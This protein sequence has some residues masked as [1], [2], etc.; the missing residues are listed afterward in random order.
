M[1]CC[2]SCFQDPTVIEFIVSNSE[3]TGVCDVC[4][5]GDQPLILSTSLA[6]LFEP[7]LLNYSYLGPDTLHDYEDPADVGE[8]LID[9]VQ[10]WDIFTDE[11]FCSGAAGDLLEEIATANW[12]DDSGEPPFAQYVLYTE[13]PSK[14]HSTMASDWDDFSYQVKSNPRQ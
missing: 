11:L 3:A 1:Y 2:P 12:D 6:D 5:A 7:L 13:R 14:W 4:A 8:F 9:L 10:E